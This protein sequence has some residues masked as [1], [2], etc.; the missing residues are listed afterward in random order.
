MKMERVKRK[1]EG[2]DKKEGRKR[3]DGRG[4]SGEVRKEK[5]A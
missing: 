2:R 4:N 5:E 1:S 3:R